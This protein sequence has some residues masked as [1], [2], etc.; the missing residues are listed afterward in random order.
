MR[1]QNM[2]ATATHHGMVRSQD[3]TTIAYETLGGGP[4]L[5]VLNGAWRAARDYLPFAR[6]LAR[7]FAVHVVDRRGRGRSGPQ[8][9]DYSIER[10]LEHLSVVR[11]RTGATILFGHS[12]G[13]LI[14]LQAARRSS[15][16]TDVVV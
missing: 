15:D 2:I 6:A 5:L 16:F 14:A 1:S 10:E 11:A 4:G 7:D 12:Y 9:T 3:G 13:G 8:G